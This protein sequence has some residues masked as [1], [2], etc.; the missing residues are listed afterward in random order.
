MASLD[1]RTA[2]AVTAAGLVGVVA[3]V[4][5]Q[6]S[7]APESVDAATL[8]TG[9]LASLVLVLIA[10]LVGTALADRVGLQ[11]YGARP[12]SDAPVG[13]SY[14]GAAATGAVVAVAILALDVAAFLPMM[15]ASAFDPATA[16]RGS[17]WLWLLASVYGG[18]TEEIVLRYG[19]LTLLVWVAWKLRSTADG[20]PT[21]GGVWVA[22]LLTSLAFGAAHL[23]TTAAVVE[24]TPVVVARAL[25]L[26]GLGG[27]VF[28]WLYWRRDLVAAMVA[29][30]SA[31]VVLHVLT[32]AVFG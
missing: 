14:A 10:A 11:A 18:I 23:P 13:I 22:I 20:R 25:I 2:L 19:L 28:G 32:P 8:A 3:V 27:V 15:D 24:L 21:A 5:L 9:L 29:H 17:L 1:W 31:D 6:L 16:E 12:A 4:P 30:F 26:N 7:Q